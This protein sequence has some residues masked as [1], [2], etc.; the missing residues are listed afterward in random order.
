MSKSTITQGEARISK[1][2]LLSVTEK[3]AIKVLTAGGHKKGSIVKAWKIAH[4][5][6]VPDYIKAED[7]AKP[8]RKRT[9]K[10]KEDSDS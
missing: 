10:K 8:K 5:L 2:W 4:G 1:Q 9:T 7:E 6:T 3:H